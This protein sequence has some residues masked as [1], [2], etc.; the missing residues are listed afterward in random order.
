MIHAVDDILSGLF[1]FFFFGDITLKTDL[2]AQKE[3]DCI[4]SKRDVGGSQ[5]NHTHPHF[6]CSQPCSKFIPITHLISFSEI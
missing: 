6:H 5:V 2:K 1:F 4:E 3:E